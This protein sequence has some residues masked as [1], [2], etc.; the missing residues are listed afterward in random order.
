MNTKKTS[1]ATRNPMA[2]ALACGAFKPRIVRA[3]TGNRAYT[4][5]DKHKSRRDW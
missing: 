3:K 2:G 1:V 5:K 4:R